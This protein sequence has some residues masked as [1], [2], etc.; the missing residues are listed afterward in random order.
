MDC[1]MNSLVPISSRD[2]LNVEIRAMRRGDMTDVIRIERESFDFPWNLRDLKL[3]LQNR[4]CAAI[5]GEAFG[6]TLGFSVFSL[7]PEE[8]EI[9]DIA[10][11]PEF[12]RC[13]IGTQ[14]VKALKF[15]AASTPGRLLWT[16]IDESNLP[17]QLFLRD[18]G[19]KAVKICKSSFSTA[20]Q[21]YRFEFKG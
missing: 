17:G 8:I 13:M 15:R 16:L 10:V 21:A 20:E 4:S 19:F 7:L 12:R 6:T 11:D 1:V 5:V 9:I 18:Q 2:P 3:T 14:L